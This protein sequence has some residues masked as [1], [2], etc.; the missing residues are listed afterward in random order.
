[1]GKKVAFIGVGNMGGAI[2]EGLVSSAALIATDVYLTDHN[3]KKI[4]KLQRQFANG[5]HAYKTID[6]VLDN[7]PEV[8][9]LAVKPQDMMEIVDKYAPRFADKLII[10]IAAGITLDTLEEHL[11]QSRVLRVMPNLPISQLSGASAIAAGSSCTQK[12]I[13]YVKELFE[14]LGVAEV[15]K[16]ELLDVE[17]AVVG[18]APAFFA[19]YIDAFSRAGVR[20]GLSGKACRDMLLSTMRG[21][22]DQLLESGQH[23]REYMEAVTSPGGTTAAALWEMEDLIMSAAGN[24]VQ[25]ALDKTDELC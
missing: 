23:P 5:L 19:L 18:C 25:A 1:M 9:I 6:E 16:E 14:V 3:D 22:A 7:D 8:V 11:G 20:T 12:D 13:D 2:L 24:G 15:M 21:C 10:S 17:A 4:E